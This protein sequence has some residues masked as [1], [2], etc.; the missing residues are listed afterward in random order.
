ME[1]NQALF[2]SSEALTFDD[3]L[4][5]PAYSEVLPVETEISS[6]LTAE[7]RL[8]IPLL[9]AAMDTVSEARLAIALA[10]EAVLASSIAI[11]HQ[12][13]RQPKWTKSNARNRE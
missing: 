11:C 6:Q 9:S 12:S 4:V 13:N 5:V 1:I 10:R 8:N 3:V 2:D 7:I